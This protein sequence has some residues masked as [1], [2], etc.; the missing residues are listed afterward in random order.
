MPESSPTPILDEL[1]A[2]VDVDPFALC[3]DVQATLDERQPEFLAELL[4]TA[5]ADGP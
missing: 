5:E 4:A 3:A 2:E 1:M